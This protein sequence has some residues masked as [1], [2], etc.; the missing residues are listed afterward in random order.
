MEGSVMTI[1]VRFEKNYPN[2]GA[3]VGEEHGL[4]DDEA[5]Q[6]IAQGV[7]VD[8]GQAPEQPAPNE[9]QLSAPAQDANGNGGGG[10]DYGP[11]KTE[12]RRMSKEELVAYAP[13]VGVTDVENKT[14][15]QLLDEVLTRR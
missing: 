4:P 1:L 10:G 7:C 6:L 11:T 2:R 5:R 8:L 14:R 3:Y 9:D 12:L 13:T 15:E